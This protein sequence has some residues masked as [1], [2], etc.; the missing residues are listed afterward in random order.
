ME[1][2]KGRL[3]KSRRAFADGAFLFP[4]VS[5]AAL[6][7]CGVLTAFFCLPGALWG[8]EGGYRIGEDGRFVQQLR[9]EA[10][11]NALY[12]E[13][14]LERQA[15]ESW[16]AALTGK[17]E[18]PFLEFSLEPGTYRYRV[19]SYDFL[20][21]PGPESEWIQ[22]VILPARQPGLLRFSPDGFYLDEDPG[23]V[24]T[25]SGRNLVEGAEIFL[26]ES[27]G[28]LIAPDTVTV[29]QSGN[30]VRLGFTDG[31]LGMG[32]YAI[33]VTNP[34][35]LSAGIENF[36]IAFRKPVDIT[37]SA[38]YRPLV[39]L[40]GS[41]NELLGTF[42][43]PAGAYSRLTILPVKQ[44]WGYAG[45][46]IEPSWN[47]FLAAKD[48]YEVQAQM[49]GAAI[50]GIY[51]RWFAGRALALGIRVGGGVY[52][53]LDYHLTFDRGSTDS[54]ALFVPAIAAGLSVQWFVKKPFFVEA[55][56]DFAHFL[57]ADDPSPAW[58]RPFAGLGWQF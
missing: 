26:R 5:L 2:S 21:R 29:G 50:Y 23:W 9:W 25:L 51:R 3:R 34:G 54:I 37:V 38:G 52:S 13:V 4:R 6:L 7:F 45:L 40:Y 57:T 27:E 16:G 42:L 18:E 32:N 1:M 35:G 47:H 49:P 10:S 43:F 17:R 39:S 31:Q 58:L 30:E 46:E 11:G 33:Q 20:E 44:Q 15:G 19:R 22:F 14:E 48:A 55:G 36:R 28:G 41:I 24:I 53:F 12:Y 8:Q 56:L